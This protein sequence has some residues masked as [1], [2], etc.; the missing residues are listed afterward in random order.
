MSSEP[1]F[2]CEW[3]QWTLSFWN[4][5]PKTHPD[6]VLYGHPGEGPYVYELICQYESKNATL[7]EECERTME[8][9]QEK[10]VRIGK[11]EGEEIRKMSD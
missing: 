10:L 5:D 6:P 1:L 11:A 2:G 3:C 7:A 4:R 8:T 9:F